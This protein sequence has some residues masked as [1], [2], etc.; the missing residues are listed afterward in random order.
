[1]WTHGH[2]YWNELMTTDVEKAKD[3]YAKTLGWTY[4]AMPMP[5]G[6]Y[7]VIGDGGKMPIGGLMDMPKEVPAGTPPHWFSYI[8]VDDVDKRV[9]AL[10][11]EG[12]TVMRPPFDIPGVGR[13]AIV[14]DSTGAVMGWM[15]PSGDV[16]Q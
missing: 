6:V 2:F 9:A 8:A 1:M 12:G 15:T 10:E 3:F 14:Q 16:P 4:E 13:I 11:K 5:D 7:H